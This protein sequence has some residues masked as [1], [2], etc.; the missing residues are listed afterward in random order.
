MGIVYHSNFLIYF[1][2]AR[3]DYFRHIGFTYKELEQENVFMPVLECYCRYDRSAYY[4]DQLEIITEF[5]MLSRLKMKFHYEVF[6]RP[7][8]EKLA[9]GYTIHAPVNRAGKPCRIPERY[10]Q[11]FQKGK[12]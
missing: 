4:D 12:E 11:A 1:E 2:I 3:T 5:E 10:A 7:D 8:N 9:T 6:R